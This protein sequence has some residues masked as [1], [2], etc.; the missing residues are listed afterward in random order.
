MS[1][2]K[3][4]FYDRLDNMSDIRLHVLLLYHFTGFIE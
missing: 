1:G 4:V 3:T 2:R